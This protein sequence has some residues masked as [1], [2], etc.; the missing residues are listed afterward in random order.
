[1]YLASTTLLSAQELPSFNDLQ[2]RFSA[3]VPSYWELK[4]FRVIASA[5]RGEPINPLAMV[6]YEADVAPKTDLFTS[7]GERAGPFAI[8]LKTHPQGQMRTIFGTMQLSYTAG[9][10]SGAPVIENP[11][12]DLGQPQD[13][14][15]QPTL[16]LGSDQQKE[17]LAALRSDAIT[18]KWPKGADGGHGM[19]LQ[20]PQPAQKLPIRE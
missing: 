7:T 12:A 6:R 18:S 1:M 2:S 13:L 11:V 17:V 4:D 3:N 9:N 8:V 10:W 14:F 15:T 20:K 5:K 16:E 19:H